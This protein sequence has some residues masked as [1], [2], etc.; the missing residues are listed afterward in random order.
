MKNGMKFHRNV[1]I[2]LH[3][4]KSEASEGGIANTLHVVGVHTCVRAC[5][6]ACVCVYVWCV[7]A[8]V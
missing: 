4:L 1:T 5:V 6:C 7:I 8:T 2:K 3:W